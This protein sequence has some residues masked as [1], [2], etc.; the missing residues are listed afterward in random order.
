[1]R[2]RP[3]NMGDAKKM[4]EWKNY[5]ETRE[6][7]IAHNKRIKWDNHLKW[8][9]AN[10]HYFKIINDGV[11]AIR[12]QDKE[13]SIWIDRKYWGKGLGTQAIKMLSKKGYTAKIVQGNIASQKAFIKAGYKPFYTVWRK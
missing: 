6:Y 1:M 7:A 13:V 8:L 2:F 10:L 4:F 12:V 3:M 9:K 11:G 5:K